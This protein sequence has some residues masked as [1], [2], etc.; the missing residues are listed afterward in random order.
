M[1]PCQSCTLGWPAAALPCRKHLSCRFCWLFHGEAE[2]AFMQH[3]AGGDCFCV[4]MG[5]FGGNQGF[6]C[7]CSSF[8]AKLPIRDEIL[9]CWVCTDN[10]CV[11]TCQKHQCAEQQWNQDRLFWELLNYTNHCGLFPPA[12]ISSQDLSSFY[13][14]QQTSP[15]SEEVESRQQLWFPSAQRFASQLSGSQMGCS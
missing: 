15:V 11:S 14:L 6:C 9:L 8:C 7:C 3:W 4:E 1:L 2:S 13:S 5:L 12:A 10:M